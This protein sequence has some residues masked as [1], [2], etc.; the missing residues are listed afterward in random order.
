MNKNK[1]ALNKNKIKINLSAAKYI[2]I[3][4]VKIGSY[5]YRKD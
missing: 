2:V 1:E 4:A 5:K 3:L